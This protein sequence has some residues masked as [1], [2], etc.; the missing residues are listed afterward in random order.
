MQK[1][2]TMMVVMLCGCSNIPDLTSPD[3]VTPTNQSVPGFEADEFFTSPPV[4]VPV[5]T[6]VLRRIENLQQR[7]A[8][9]RGFDVDFGG[10]VRRVDQ[11]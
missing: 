6:E 8:A 5:D 11:P 4:Q 7:A 9:L 1:A 10:R 2:V 3:R